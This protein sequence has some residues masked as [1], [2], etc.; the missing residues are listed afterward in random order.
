MKQDI[1]QI[2]T[3]LQTFYHK[4]GAVPT[5]RELMEICGVK[6]MRSVY[7]RIEILTETGYLFKQWDKLDVTDKISWFPVYGTVQAW[8]LAP[9]TDEMKYDISLQQYLVE[10]PQATY[11]VKVKGYSMKN[12][13]LV[14]GDYAIVDRSQ[15][16]PRSGQIVIASL[17][18]G[19]TIK[20]FRSEQ[21][22]I[23]LQP[24]NDEM[25]PIHPDGELM[26]QGVVVWSFRKF[27]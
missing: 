27:E 16:N 25:S 1:N 23:W 4:H 26:I 11:F 14:P 12:V 9:A 6:W 5:V 8:F 20:T 3:N 2:I 21:W 13:W 19:L 15:Q 17:P 10:K 22:K 24:E 18:D 7:R